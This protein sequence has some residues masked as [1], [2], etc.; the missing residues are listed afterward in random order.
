MTMSLTA[1]TVHLEVYY[2]KAIT[3][4][5]MATAVSFVQILLVIKQMEATATQAASAR[6][7]LITIGGQAIMDSY[8]CL[9]HLTA[10]VVME[11]VFSS[12]ATAAFFKFVMFSIFEMRYLLTIWKARRPDTNEGWIAMRRE[13][14]ILYSRFYGALVGGI[15]LMYHT[16]DYA[17]YLVLLFYSFWLPQ[18]VYNIRHDCRRPLLPQY[19]VGISVSRLLIP[20]YIFLCPKNLL[21]LEPEPKLAGA[22]VAWVSLQ[23]ALLLLQH[24]WGAHCFIPKRLLPEK[25]DYFRP[26]GGETLNPKP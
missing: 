12:L 14:S 13:L 15:F 18:I 16:Q 5:L 1:A 9:A 4:S 6:V 21:R 3:Y 2:N 22:L 20:L 23:A 17:K 11:A 25:Y 26:Y 8:L 7:S 10:G 24:R 19:I